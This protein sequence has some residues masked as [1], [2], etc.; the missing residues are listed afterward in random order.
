MITDIWLKVEE[1]PTQYANLLMQVDLYRQ[2]ETG[3]SEFPVATSDRPVF[4]SGSWQHSL[5]LVAPRQSA[6]AEAIDSKRLPPGTYLL[7]L[8]VDQS[9][10]LQ[11]DYRAKLDEED[12]VGEITLESRWPAGYG[13]MTVVNFT[14][15]EVP[16]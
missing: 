13:K 12:L 5:T 3:W 10:K 7:K 9:G 14:A 8:L 2:T 11:K 1:I 6:W 4:E 16:K 15:T